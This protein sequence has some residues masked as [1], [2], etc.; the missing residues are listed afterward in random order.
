MVDLEKDKY[1]LWKQEMRRKVE[2]DTE[3]LNDDVPQ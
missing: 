2:I 1:Y 3:D